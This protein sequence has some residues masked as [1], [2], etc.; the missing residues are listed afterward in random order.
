MNVLTKTEPQD[1]LCLCLFSYLTFIHLLIC[2]PAI[3]PPKS[4]L[5]ILIQPCASVFLYKSSFFLC[6]YFSLCPVCLSTCLILLICSVCQLL[7]YTVFP[8]LCQ[9]FS[10]CQSFSLSVSPFVSFS[11]SSLMYRFMCMCVCELLC[12]WACLSCMRWCVFLSGA[13]AP[14]FHVWIIAVLVEVWNI[15]QWWNIFLF[16]V[17]LAFI[18][19]IGRK[20]PTVQRKHLQYLITD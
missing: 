1:C 19:D 12:A 2:L 7:A 4:V 20:L 5:L 6:I 3:C 9:C 8:S 13:C 15:F 16:W 17:F 10:S 18:T 14:W 11:F